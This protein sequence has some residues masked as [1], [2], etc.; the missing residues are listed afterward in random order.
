M[1][2]SS[3]N[4]SRYLLRNSFFSWLVNP[5]PP[6]PPR[7]AVFSPMATYICNTDNP[8]ALVFSASHNTKTAYCSETAGISHI[9]QCFR[10]T[11]SSRTSLPSAFP[12]GLA[13]GFVCGFMRYS[14]ENIPLPLPVR[15]AKQETALRSLLCPG[16][17]P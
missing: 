4:I 3:S 12:P 11:G 15:A 1:S 5:K 14:L 7:R 17:L 6:F 10:R 8:P 9:P 13:F 2:F 16:A